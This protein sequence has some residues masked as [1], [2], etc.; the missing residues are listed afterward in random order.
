MRIKG[1]VVY[2]EVKVKNV[3]R[4]SW[5][6]CACVESKVDYFFANNGGVEACGG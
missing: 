1:E 6:S 5:K 4:G 2:V 3:H